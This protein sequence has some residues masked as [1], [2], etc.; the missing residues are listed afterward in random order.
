MLLIHVQ[1][2][3]HLIQKLLTYEMKCPFYFSIYLG[4]VALHVDALYILQSRD[5]I[6]F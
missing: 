2:L 3:I 6:I 1:E 4:T 5:F